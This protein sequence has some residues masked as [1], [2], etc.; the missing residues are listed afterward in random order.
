MK[1]SDFIVTYIEHKNI[2]TVFGYQGGSIA[3]LIDSL[4]K[5][6]KN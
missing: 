3:D 6:K 2:D 1:L 5:S 4:S